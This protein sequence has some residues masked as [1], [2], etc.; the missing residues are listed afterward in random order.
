MIMIK[1]Y[2]R[3][4]MILVIVYLVIVVFIFM[5]DQIISQ[6]GNKKKISKDHK[7]KDGKE[8]IIQLL[9]KIKL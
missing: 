7:D 2:V 4:I 6:D 3:I 1:V 8:L 9:N 5:I